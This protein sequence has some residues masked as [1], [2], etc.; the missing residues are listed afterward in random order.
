MTEKYL[1]HRISM[2][3]CDPEI[4]GSALLL[5]TELAETGE[6]GFCGCGRSATLKAELFFRDDRNLTLIAEDERK[7]FYCASCFLKL[8]GGLRS[9]PQ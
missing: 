1:A 7:K 4:K 3:L 2:L 5:I 6:R 8:A 9:D